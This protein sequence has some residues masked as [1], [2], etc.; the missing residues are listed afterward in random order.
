[1]SK[2]VKE[3]ICRELAERFRDVDACMVFDPTGLDGATANR[4]RGEMS[5]ARVRMRMAKNSLL[6]RA[7][8]GLPL[9]PV[10]GLL[11][12]PC[13]LAWGS[14]SIVDV[15]KLLVAKA[16]EMPGLV[17]KGA[18]MEGQPLDAA[19]AANLSR[20]PTLGEIRASVVGQVLAPGAGLAAAV[21]GPGAM[22]ANL[23]K[24]RIEQLGE[25]EG[26][27]AAA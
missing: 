13:A 5:Q 23:L 14:E 7:L 1:M 19:A 9:E 6:K 3:T 16:K 8:V 21:L 22:I 27:P 2:Q 10:G 20:M 12:G 24:G 18:V 11:D 17:I 26:E 15:A 25:S 4:L